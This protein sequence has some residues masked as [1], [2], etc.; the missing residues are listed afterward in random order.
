MN[1]PPA[2]FPLIV[3]KQFDVDLNG[4]IA[5]EHV[6]ATLSLIASKW[7]DIN[8]IE[9]RKLLMSMLSAGLPLLASKWS[10]V[11]LKKECC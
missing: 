2:N 8:L 4:N 6:S 9:T 1:I 5:N 3:C 7:S 10:D 11:G